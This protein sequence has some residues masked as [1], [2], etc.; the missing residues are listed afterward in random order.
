MPLKKH[1]KKSMNLSVTTRAS[2]TLLKTSKLPLRSLN[3]FRF[4][5]A[6]LVTTALCHKRLT[7]AMKLLRK[8]PKRGW[9]SKLGRA[10]NFPSLM[11]L[12]S[13]QMKK[14]SNAWV[15]SLTSLLPFAKQKSK[16]LTTWE[17]MWKRP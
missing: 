16:K 5:S 12:W 7:L 8:L 2:S 14:P 17:L 4:N 11:M 13:K 3:R 9:I 6:T 10:L 1:V 15:N